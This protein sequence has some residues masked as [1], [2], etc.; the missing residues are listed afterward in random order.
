VVKH[1]GTEVGKLSAK[2]PQYVRVCF[3]FEGNSDTQCLSDTQTKQKERYGNWSEEAKD[4]LER[5]ETIRSYSVHGDI[6]YGTWLRRS[7]KGVEV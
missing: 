2:L 3:K 5:P 7:E 6:S 1:S 4:F